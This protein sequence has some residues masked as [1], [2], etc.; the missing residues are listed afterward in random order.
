VLPEGSGP[1]WRAVLE[2]CRALTFA[3]E[4]Y[5]CGGVVAGNRLFEDAAEVVFR[6]LLGADLP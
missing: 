6:E 2:K 1:F 3:R 4:P 5:H